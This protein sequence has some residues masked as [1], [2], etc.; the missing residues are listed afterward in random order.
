MMNIFSSFYQ[1][2]LLL[3]LAPLAAG[4]VKFFKA[5]FQG[6]KGAS[7]F[8]PYFTLLTLLKKEMVI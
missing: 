5:R 8:L 4:L 2:I 6:R 1:L 3:L 7:P